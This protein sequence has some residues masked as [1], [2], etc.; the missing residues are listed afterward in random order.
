MATITDFF[1]VHGK[2]IISGSTPGA[3]FNWYQNG[4]AASVS[5]DTTGGRGSH[6]ALKIQQTAAGVSIIGFDVVAGNRKVLAFGWFKLNQLSTLA[7]ANLIQ[8]GGPT[9]QPGIQVTTGGI[10]R[11]FA[12]ATTAVY[13]GTFSTGTWYW[14]ECLIDTSG[15]TFTIDWK[16][17]DDTLKTFV[18]QSQAAI[19]GQTAADQT[20]IK[21]GQNAS[22]AQ[23]GDAT[24]TGGWFHDCGYGLVS[25]DYPLANPLETVLLNPSA[26]GTHSL[27]TG[28]FTK[29]GSVAITAGE[30]TSFGELDEQPISATDWVA[31]TAIDAAAFVEYQCDYAVADARDPVA[32]KFYTEHQGAATGAYTF[33]ARVRENATDSADITTGGT[34][35][36]TTVI[37]R[38]LVLG[39]R[40][41]GGGAWTN[42]TAKAARLRFGYSGD[43]TPD[44]QLNGWFA[45][46]LMP[47]SL[48]TTLTNT[49][50]ATAGSSA[51]VA[52]ARIRRATPT[53]SAGSTPSV[54]KTPGVVRS[55]ATGSS[56]LV[57]KIPKL[58]RALTGGSTASVVSSK[59]KVA[60]SSITASAPTLTVSRLLA[61]LNVTTA[62]AGSIS[63]VVKI[64]KRITTVAA[65]TSITILKAPARV[66]SATGGSSASALKRPGRVIAASAGSTASALQALV[67][68]RVITATASSAVSVIRRPGKVS[69][70]SAANSSSVARV[71]SR[72]RT[73]TATAAGGAVVVKVPKLTRVVSAASSSSVL[74]T[75]GVVRSVSAGS[76][77]TALRRPGR[78]ASVAASSSSSVLRSAGVQASLA[79]G[80][81]VSMAMSAG[82]S[83]VLS[84]SSSS[85]SVV[86]AG[87]SVVV[88]AGSLVSTIR[89]IITG[90]GF[91]GLAG[92]TNRIGGSAVGR[93]AINALMAVPGAGKLRGNSNH[94]GK[95]D[96]SPADGTGIIE[97]D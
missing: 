72:L 80:S 11:A 84:A 69:T 49:S 23:L 60:L 85:S 92:R 26:C 64:P 83:V 31:Q 38:S 13:S 94:T 5:V 96:H 35:S 81:V 75:P 50:T 54:L 53:A 62:S 1:G 57:S 46:A 82:R 32:L 78:V 14:I 63:S 79:A 27:G 25:T 51:S 44:V 87:V 22:A 8:C 34:K 39:A 65:G 37:R 68:L 36:A 4:T 48:S 76:T 88:A 66:V 52:A 86:Q 93:S 10:L 9:T 28:L 21:F 16:V 71:A 15:T 6:P 74:K 33:E 30:T 2:E 43:A 19:A 17:Y 70:I 20:S 59:V 90:G 89:T 58:V 7:S 45:E 29:T 77:A 3:A 55:V 40:L 24:H 61:R 56:A 91:R 73:I 12:G 95:I 67:Q 97:G 42:A 18:A 47:V 41:G